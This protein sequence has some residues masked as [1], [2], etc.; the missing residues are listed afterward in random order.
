MAGWACHLL[1]T[2]P[3]PLPGHAPP[4]H[5]AHVYPT[6]EVLKRLGDEQKGQLLSQWFTLLE[7]I[8]GLLRNTWAQSAAV[9]TRTPRSGP[10]CRSPGRCSRAPAAVVGHK[11]RAS[12]TGLASTRPSGAGPRRGGEPAAGQ[13]AA[14]SGLVLRQARGQRRVGLAR[15]LRRH[16]RRSPHQDG[17]THQDG[18]RSEL[19]VGRVRTP[20]SRGSSA[21]ERSA[22]NRV[23]AGSSP[24]SGTHRTSADSTPSA[25]VTSN[26]YDYVRTATPALTPPRARAPRRVRPRGSSGAKKISSLES[27]G[28]VTGVLHETLL[29]T[30]EVLDVETTGEICCGAVRK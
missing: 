15:A 25:L 26:S 30:S 29:P 13:R 9:W 17:G 2:P 22:L 27:C 3:V 28:V 12:A 1:N 19:R 7:D 18:E 20:V 4:H 11:W 6:V 14:P 21:V 24:A 10:S 23:D 8:A 5:I 16:R